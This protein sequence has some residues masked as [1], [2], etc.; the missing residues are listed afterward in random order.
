MFGAVA[1]AVGLLRPPH[2][3]V[4]GGRSV[5]LSREYPRKDYCKSPSQSTGK[6]ERRVGEGPEET[7][8][9]KP[10]LNEIRAESLPTFFLVTTQ[11][12]RN[13][14]THLDFKSLLKI[15]VAQTP[16]EASNVN[17]YRSPLTN[18]PLRATGFSRRES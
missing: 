10:A 18:A 8:A 12:Y 4:A 13:W 9:Y 5:R 14:P 11:H 7:N 6:G 1:V 2:P 3:A 15:S 16:S 17:S